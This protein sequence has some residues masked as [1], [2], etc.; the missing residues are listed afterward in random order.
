MCKIEFFAGLVYIINFKIVDRKSLKK[1][2]LCL[3]LIS[4]GLVSAQE[5][6]LTIDKLSTNPVFVF[7]ESMLDEEDATSQNVSAM[8]TSASDVF[9]SNAG[10]A[11][12][13][14]RFRTRGY[15]QEY[16]QSTINGITFNDQERGVFSYSMLGGLNDVVK[17]SED[18]FGTAATDFGFGGVGGASNIIMRASK[19]APGSR[20]SLAYTNRN[21]KMRGTYTFSTGLSP[22]GWAFTAALGY[23]WADEGFIEGTFYNSLGYM[24]ALEKVIN[25]KHS[26][27]LTS[28]GAPTQ[29]GN[30]SANVQEVYDLVGSN[31]Y[32]S[33]WGYQDGKKRNSRIVTDYEP[34]VMLNHL[35]DVSKFTKINTGL[36]T[37]ASGYGSTAIA[38]NNA[39]NPN[40]TY[41]RNLPGYQSTQEMKDFYTQ[42]WQSKDPTR[43]QVNWDRLYMVNKL[44]NDA[45][46]SA[47]YILEERHNDQNE[48]ILN[49]TINHRVDNNLKV[50]GGL[51]ARYTKGMHYKTI[52]DMLGSNYYDDIDQYTENYSPISHDI[53]YNDLNDPYSQKIKDDVFGYNYN[54]Y[55]Y[56]AN[57]WFQNNYTYSHLDFY[58]GAKLGYKSFQREG[59]MKNGRA[60]EN[61]FGYGKAHTFVNQSVKG[62]LTWKPSGNHIF[63]VNALYETRPPQP[64]NAYISPRIKDDAV[65][66]LSSESVTHGDINYNF[67]TRF[68]HGK[69]SLYRTKF[70]NQIEIDNFF[71]DELRT[72][73]NSVMTGVDKV[74]QGVEFGITGDIMPDLSATLIGSVSDYFYDS[75][76]TTTIS[77]ENGMSADV[78]RT[79]YLKNFKVGGTPQTAINF[80][81]S[82]RAPDYWFF[83]LGCSYYD[84]VYVDLTP[85]RRTAEILNFTSDSYDD[86]M[87][88]AHKIVDQEKYDGGFVVD[89]SIGKS[90][91]LKNGHN[92]NFNLQLSNLLNNTKLRSGGYEQGRF[93]YT[94]YNVD[95]FP[96]Y[97]YYAQGFNC[98]LLVAYK[99]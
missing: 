70:N 7:N 74:H 23:R 96:P 38:Y 59:L 53:Q 28:F 2:L 21:Y 62:G 41:Y 55:V 57:A 6:T 43:T 25:S 12:S 66:G 73:V 46:Q 80:E 67:N 10:Y 82:Y 51:E 71:N 15:N 92:L 56:S 4:A 1:Y 31:Y 54:M 91:R 22:S 42:I 50:N 19:Y 39:S 89:A 75:R 29:R 76:P 34:V 36:A 83:D 87:A 79:A 61:S 90:L 44:A 88:L 98:Y 52:A 68:F 49:S 40:P 78:V 14:M 30:S 48:I 35:W 72:F 16:I 97:Y 84:R 33:Y 37:R 47:R 69:V 99:F 32:N 63:S 95:K 27:S 86:Y 60:P 58:Y 81:L 77:V 20:V 64:N 85:I 93:D 17:N 24:V 26:I 8:M 13:A 11:F 45:G 94:N 5:D 3:F 18:V 9:A 65:K